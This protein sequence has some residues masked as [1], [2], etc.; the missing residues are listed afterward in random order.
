MDVSSLNEHVAHVMW[1]RHFLWQSTALRSR[2]AVLKASLGAAQCRPG[3]TERHGFKP[4]HE[5]RRGSRRREES[6][7]ELPTPFIITS[8]IFFPSFLLF[9]ARALPGEQLVWPSDRGPLGHFPVSVSCRLRPCQAFREP[10]RPP[11]SRRA[12]AADPASC[13]RKKR[14]REREREMPIF[15]EAVT[16]SH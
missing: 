12:P 16:S 2:G 3:S 15:V 9:C 8:S 14:E 13:R 6:G 5:K 10:A 7:R 11:G 1:P 4:G